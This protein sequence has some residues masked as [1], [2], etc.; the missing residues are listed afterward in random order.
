[1][2]SLTGLTV[3]WEQREVPSNEWERLT[4]G[5]LQSNLII[6]T[7]VLSLLSSV[8]NTILK[9]DAGPF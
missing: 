4:G 7:A 6:M 1:M 3:D 9:C 5:D 8:Y 2:A